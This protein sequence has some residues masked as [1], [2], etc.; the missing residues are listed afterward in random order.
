MLE[1][2][3]AR[4]DL[5]PAAVAECIDR[6]GFG[7]MF[8]PAH[9]QAMTLRD[10]GPPRGLAVRTVFN[11]LGPLSNPAGATRQL[12]GVSDPRAPAERSP[13]LSRR[14]EASAR[15]CV[16]SDDGYDEVSVSAPTRAVELRDGAL[17]ELTIEPEELGFDRVADGAFSAGTPEQNAAIT[18]AVLVASR[19]RADGRAANAGAAIYV[20]GGAASIPIRGDQGRCDDRFRS[21]RTTCSSA[22]WPFRRSWPRNER[23]A[24]TSARG[25][26]SSGSTASEP[27]GRSAS[28][29]PHSGRPRRPARSRGDSRHGTSVIAEH[30]RRS[31]SAGTIRDGSTVEEIVGFYERGGAA[32]ISVLTE[33]A[34][35]G[36]SLDDLVAARVAC[37]PADSPQGLH[38]RPLPALRGAAGRRRRDPAGRR[39]DP[40][41]SCS[42]TCTAEAHALDLDVIVEVHYEDDLESALAIDADVIGINNRDLEDF[43][44]DL[45]DD[46]RAAAGGPGGQDG[47]LRIGDPTRE[48]VEEL[49]RVG[50]DAVLVGEALMRRDDPEAALR[51][52]TGRPRGDNAWLLTP[53]WPFL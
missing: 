49:E 20:A 45:G 18:R 22:T 17:T 38:D 9:H 35:F 48:D 50:V 3:G 8:A 19:T 11:I 16:S 1:A 10:R 6:I 25:D 21:R 41:R 23:A 12:I 36:G 30:K 43:S 13:A 7:F 15:S 53:A 5:E 26:P 44:V 28:S 2:L 39:D 33:E 46:L 51:T 4:I 24:G 52:L 14:S 34:H 32:A 29:R 27:S 31:P 37:E 47:R 42:P 40:S